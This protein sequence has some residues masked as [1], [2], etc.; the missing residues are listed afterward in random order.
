[1]TDIG[2]ELARIQA[3]D[4][5]RALRLQVAGLRQLI[6]CALCSVCGDELADMAP[7]TDDE[8]HLCHAECLEKKEMSDGL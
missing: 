5:E 8:G 7:G 4:T 1:M 2:E 3:A 6:S